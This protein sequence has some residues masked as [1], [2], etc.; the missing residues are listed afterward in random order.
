MPDL[1]DRLADSVSDALIEHQER[2]ETQQRT[3]P[4]GCGCR[5]MTEDPDR[6]DC[7]CNGPCCFDPD[8]WDG[9]R[10]AEALADALLPVINAIITEARADERRNIAERIRAR[11]D[12]NE[13]WLRDEVITDDGF[14]QTIGLSVVRD[15]R[16]LAARSARET[17]GG[18]P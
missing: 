4:S 2:Q 16:G 8:W 18:Q 7:A 5:Y 3:C 11:C 12:E 6:R 10:D 13:K 1:R 14:A 15:M 17:G 9:L